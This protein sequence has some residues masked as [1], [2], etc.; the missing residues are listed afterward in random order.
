MALGLV[1]RFNGDEG[2]QK[3]SD[4]IR[5]VLNDKQLL[6]TTL[7]NSQA[8]KLCQLNVLEERLTQLPQLRLQ[9]KKT[10]LLLFEKKR[11]RSRIVEVLDAIECEMYEVEKLSK[12]EENVS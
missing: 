1:E 8:F 11:N 9:K 2:L 10:D 6:V 3:F 4:A 12:I 5:Q 7:Q